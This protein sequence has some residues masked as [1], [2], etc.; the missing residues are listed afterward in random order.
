MGKGDKSL[1][2]KLK[3]LGFREKVI[4]LTRF[5]KFI[6]KISSQEIYKPKIIDDWLCNNINGKVYEVYNI[7]YWYTQLRVDGVVIFDKRRFEDEELLIK[8]PQ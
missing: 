4:E 1:W 2:T 6:N 5:Q 3:E 8:I 7:D